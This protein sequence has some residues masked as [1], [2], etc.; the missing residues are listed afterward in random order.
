MLTSDYFCSLSYDEFSILPIFEESVALDKLE[1]S[2]YRCVIRRWVSHDPESRVPMAPLLEKLFSKLW[3]L[4]DY[5]R[6]LAISVDVL[7]MANLVQFNFQVRTALFRIL[8]RH[9]R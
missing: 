7:G 4:D 3:T 5:E 8:Y 9:G 2:K 1:E 6:A